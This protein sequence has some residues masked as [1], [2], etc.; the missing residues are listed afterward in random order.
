MKSRC[1]NP[2]MANYADYGGRG[3]RVCNRWSR[4]FAHFLEDMGPKPKSANTGKLR[5]FSI[6]RVDNEKGYG[7]GNCRWSTFT[8][9]ARNRRSNNLLT[10][11]GRTQ[12]LTEWALEVG[13]SKVTL[14]W[15]VRRGWLAEDALKPPSPRPILG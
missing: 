15:R 1:Q 12:T 7:P 8:E 6:E 14:R 5:E 11:D 3:I 4:S 13:M 2:N 9:Q 10:H